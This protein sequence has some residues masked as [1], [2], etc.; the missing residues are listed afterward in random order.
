MM[1]R[2]NLGTVI[3]YC[4]QLIKGFKTRQRVDSSR[5]ILYLDT[6]PTGL[7]LTQSYTLAAGAGVKIRV[8]YSH[9]LAETP[10]A[11]LQY[12]F[13]N[14]E[15]G[16]NYIEYRENPSDPYTTEWTLALVNL[17]STSDTFDVY[18]GVKSSA[19]GTLSIA[20]V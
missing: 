7:P 11:Q 3:A 19:P 13:A 8:T 5:A 15:G 9:P 20:T 10:Y 2:E 17:S 14:S 1:Q 4:D 6:R 12:E 18:F 16:I